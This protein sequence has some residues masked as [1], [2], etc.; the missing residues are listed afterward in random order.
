MASLNR[1]KRENL[2]RMFRDRFNDD[3][4]ECKVYSHDVGELPNLIA[5]LVGNT[6]PGAIVQPESEGEISWLLHWAND[7]GI[8]VTPRGKAT[9]GYGGV[10]PKKNGLVVDFFRMRKVLSINKGNLTVTVQPGIVWEALEKELIRNGLM[11]R[12]YPT[13]YPSSTVAGWAAQGGAGIGS[14]SA[15]WFKDNIEKIKIVAADGAVKTLFGKDLDMVYEAEG[16]TGI[17][18]EVTI[19]VMPLKVLLKKACSHPD[20]RVFNRFLMKISEKN[21]PLWSVLFINPKMA[22]LK[23][24]VPLRL[25]HDCPAE[26]PVN[27]PREYIT[28]IAY[29]EENKTLVEESLE[30]LQKE[31]GMNPLSEIM[32][33]H[34]WENRFKLMSIKRLGPSLVPAEIIVP[35]EKMDVVLEEIGAKVHQPIVKEGIL[36]KSGQGGKPEVVILGFIPGDSRTF[37]FN[38]IFAL[39]LSIMKIAVKHGGRP[40]ATGKYFSAKADLILGRGKKQRLREYKKQIDPKNILNPGKVIGGGG[41]LSLAIRLAW[42]FAS[43][44]RPFGNLARTRI[45]ER[46]KPKVKDIPGDVAWY[47]Y[48]CSQ[49]GFCVEECD[50]FY[51]RGWESQSPR[52]KWYWIRERLAKREQWNQQVIDTFLVCTTCELCNNRCSASLPIEESWMKLR[53][54]LIHKENRM[55]FPPFEMM[56]AA[57]QKEGDIWAGYRKDRSVWFPED[58][59]AEHT[60]KKAEYA[61]FAGCTASYVEHDIGIASVR[62]LHDA[63]VDFAYTGEEES[64]CG[65]P[66]LVA[67]KWDEFA[68]TI[69]KNIKAVKKT[70]ASTVVCSCPACDMMWRHVYPKWAK[71]LGI[72]F[73]IKTKHYSEVIAGKIKS[74]DFTFPGNGHEKEKVTWHDSCHMGRVSGVYDPPRDMIKAIPGVDFVEMPFNREN[75]H[76]CGSVLTLIKEPDVAAEIGQMRLEEALSV[77]ANKVVA[78]CPCCE[79]QLRVAA[80]KRKVPVEVVDLAAFTAERLGYKLPNPN[81]EVKKQWRVFE[82][83]IKL[84][85][86]EGFAALMKDMFPELIKAMPFGMGGMMKVMGK[87]PGMLTLMKPMFPV[88]FPIFLP[89]MMPKVLPDMMKR[90]GKLVPMPDYMMEQM[91]DLLPR[92]MDNLMPHM[93]KDVIPLITQPLVQYLK[94]A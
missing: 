1:K 70:G 15:G 83:M 59:K 10:L 49:C 58:L 21:L 35:L 16:I 2:K 4:F 25:H 90:I 11:L 19:R 39:V 63:G 85:T 79:F 87:I 81:P 9:S 5:P 57:L 46:I 72:E 60:D 7:N 6:I 14:Y 3:R 66:M 20:V 80:D 36:V 38:F 75:A 52:G 41:I 44:I 30:R 71:K 43:F 33:E 51:G 94:T 64:C 27:L 50:Q 78:L 61:Y 89:M 68:E 77:D 55:T 62:L 74:G 28:L 45:G 82:G 48:A 12:L 69:Q 76:C 24:S 84:M 73:D 42:A 86:P 53:G 31:F 32:T 23:R 47:A 91:P 65:T 92:V 93:L 56:S 26:E 13:S 18:S 37:K 34:E 8:K 17:I 54:K 22:E 67:G 88:L 29:T 40:Y